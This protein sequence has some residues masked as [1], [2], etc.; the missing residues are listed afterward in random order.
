ME[1]QF[2]KEFQH[3]SVGNLPD[4]F[5]IYDTQEYISKFRSSFLHNI[6]INAG[7]SIDEVCR[8][9]SVSKSDLKRIESGD[10]I[11]KDLMV[12]N[13][14][15]LLYGI[16]YGNLL[17][18]LKLARKHPRDVELKMAACHDQ[19]IN[20]ETMEMLTDIVSRLKDL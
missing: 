1:E 5:K 8:E 6:R 7:I 16:D 11:P 3:I 20:K 14:M 17:Y 2:N 19:N 9:V 10:I 4:N 13:K 15:S 18:L 12:L